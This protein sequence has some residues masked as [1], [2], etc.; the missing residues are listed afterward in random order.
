M[1]TRDGELVHSVATTAFQ[2]ENTAVSLLKNCG[3]RVGEQ[4]GFFA[5]E[6]RAKGPPTHPP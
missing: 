3:H 6:P 5:R 1:F 2:F 4:V